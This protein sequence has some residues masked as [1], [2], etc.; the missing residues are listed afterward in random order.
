MGPKGLVEWFPSCSVLVAGCRC[1][2][3][4]AIVNGLCVGADIAVGDVNVEV[5]SC[6]FVGGFALGGD[7]S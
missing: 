1:R 5:L 3:C 7:A 2:L 6:K 4:G